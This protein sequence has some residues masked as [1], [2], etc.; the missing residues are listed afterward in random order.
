ML[1]DVLRWAL[2]LWLAAL[3]AGISGLGVYL[4]LWTRPAEDTPLLGRVLYHAGQG[5]IALTVLLLAG[6][7][8]GIAVVGA[9]ALLGR[10]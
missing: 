9:L 2:T 3:M 4:A 10:H 8:F 6:G 1:V 7:V 5:V